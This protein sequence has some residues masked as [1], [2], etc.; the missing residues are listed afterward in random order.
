VLQEKEIIKVGGTDIIHVDVRII[1]ATNK[2]LL[3][4]CQE[5]R[6]RE[7][8]YYRLKRLYLKTPPLR[9]RT[10]DLDELTRHF[11]IKN[12]RPDLQLSPEVKSILAAHT[13]SGNVREL[14]STIEYMVAVCSES[15]ITSEHLPQDFFSRS[16]PPS[17]DS[18]T[19]NLCSK[20]VL[21]EFL[22]IMR[23]IYEYNKMGKSIG[24]KTISDL[25][26]QFAHFMS[27][28]QIRKRTDILTDMDLLVKARGRAGMLLSLKGTNYIENHME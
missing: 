4:M 26:R 22:F 5:G 17:V 2:D 6:F 10:E 25:S 15:I 11:L 19:E 7:D 13:W 18:I 3:K 14:E 20:G 23:T 12:H 16:F 8:L 24:R 27:E 1:A 21:D 9:S 28:E